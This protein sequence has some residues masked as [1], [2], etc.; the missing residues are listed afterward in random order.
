MMLGVTRPNQKVPKESGRKIKARRPTMSDLKFNSNNSK[1]RFK[2]TV[3]TVVVQNGRLLM[4]REARGA[5]RRKWNLPGGKVDQG[6][7]LVAAAR[8]ETLEETGCVVRLTG[9]LGLYAYMTTS[10]KHSLRFIFWAQM[11]GGS[12]Q[13]D[14]DEV[15]D[16]QW[17]DLDEV[18]DMSVHELWKPS[19]LKRVLR[20]VLRERRYPMSMLRDLE[21]AAVASA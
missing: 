19:V 9:V 15:L 6:E 17:F 14:L 16:A 13:A 8:R 20:D 2:P 21:A 11:V 5:D 12:L 4:V 1:S 7:A 3:A 10:R 18:R